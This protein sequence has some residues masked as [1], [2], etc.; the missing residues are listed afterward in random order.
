M[1][2]KYMIRREFYGLMPNLGVFDTKSLAERQIDLLLVKKAVK[3]GRW[4]E[5]WGRKHMKL[6][7]IGMPS[8]WIAVA[9]SS[10]DPVHAAKN[11]TSDL[12][13]LEREAGFSDFSV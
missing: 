5:K 1:K 10:R 13:R 12:R 4:E 8:K 3:S 9:G 6:T 7:M 11:F 2:K